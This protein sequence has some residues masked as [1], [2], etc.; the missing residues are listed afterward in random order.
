MDR[1]GALLQPFTIKHLTF[2]NRVMSTGHAPGYGKDGKPQERYQLYHEEKAKGGIGLSIFGGSTTVAVDSPANEYNQISAADDSVI[3]YFKEFAERMHGH[4]AKLMIQLTHIGRKMQWQTDPWLA[5]IGP[6]RVRETYHRSHPKEMEEFDIRRVILAFGQAARRC[7]E[8]DLDGFEIHCA[9]QALIDSF[10]SPE[11]NQRTDKYGGSLENRMRFGFEVFDEVRKQVGDDY[12]VG[13]RMSGDELYDQGL[14]PDDCV[15]IIKAHHDRGY[16]DFVDVIGGGFRNSIDLDIAMASMRMPVTP[17]L[18][19]ASRIK[20]QIGIPAIHGQRVPDVEAAN[21]AIEEG[22][23]DLVGMTRPHIADPHLVRKMMAGD[24]EGIRP[25][26]GSNYCIDRVVGMGE[27]LCVHNVATS[28][29]SFMPQVI[30]KADTK[31]KVVVVGAGPGGL[32]A[33]RVSAERGHNV[34]LFEADDKCGGQ[35][36]IAAKA[37]HRESLDGITRWLQG[38]MAALGVD[39]RLSTPA[40]AAM[41]VAEKPDYVIIATG[42]D[43]DLGDF[44]GNDLAVSSWDILSGA[45]APGENVMVYDDDGRHSG[46]SAAE[47]MTSR[48]VAVEIVTPDRHVAWQVGPSSQPQY[49]KRFYDGGAIL[50]PDHRLMRLYREGNKLVAVLANELN[51][52]QEEREVDQVVA[53][54]GS[55]PRDGVYFDLKAQSRNGG[56]VDLEAMVAGGP[57]TIERNP[58]GSFMLFRVGDALSSRDIHAAIFD[59][60]RL[61]KGF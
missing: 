37:P 55:K 61:C 14:S 5:P 23:C 49:L 7:K 42:G 33:A 39:L 17:F 53:E 36:N 43:A 31:R 19:L 41:V 52:D 44:E 48:D 29:E 15:D 1:F 46:V 9:F 22:H 30:A 34:V 60:L 12:V 16:I 18:Y 50:T 54:R 26:V 57:Q 47:F 27:A 2:K 13:I 20:Q 45:V 35:I 32:E 28:R 38:R 51:G 10:W 11:A 56:E 58:D 21:R 24:V 59:S 6:S 25:C 4:G 40:D 8:G 3:P